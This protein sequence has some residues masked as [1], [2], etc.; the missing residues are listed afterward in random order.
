MY[1]VSYVIA[2]TLLIISYG[3]FSK[4]KFCSIRITILFIPVAAPECYGNNIY[5]RSR[6]TVRL[7]YGPSSATG[8][9]QACVN[10][11]YVDVCA[12]T[13]GVQYFADR[14]CNSVDSSYSKLI[15]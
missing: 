14:A 1:I 4:Q 10:N 8:Y 11:R 6:S 15:V 3:N 5:L 13:N 2:S 9:V 7:P 12:T